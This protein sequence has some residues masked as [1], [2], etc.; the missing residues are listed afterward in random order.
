MKVHVFELLLALLAVCD[1][2]SSVSYYYPQKINPALGKPVT[3]SP[4]FATCGEMAVE[5]IC[6][7][8]TNTVSD[9]DKRPTTCD[10]ACPEGD[11]LPA[12][13]AV[14][15]NIGDWSTNCVTKDYDTAKFSPS[16]NLQSNY[17]VE[18][19]AGAASGRCYVSLINANV[20]PFI[21]MPTWS[22]SVSM[23][24]KPKAGIGG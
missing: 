3:I 21:L 20:I 6:E 5:N 15:E 19:K 24:I 4:E 22:M 13:V 23:W 8:R 10:L 9:C 11:I 16:D 1:H 2:T 18:F 14:F 17:V 7:S 12:S